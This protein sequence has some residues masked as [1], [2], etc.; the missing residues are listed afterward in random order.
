MI[1][2]F[3]LRFI[4]PP[5]GACCERCGYFLPVAMV[6]AGMWDV[7]CKECAKLEVAKLFERSEEKRAEV[8]QLRRGA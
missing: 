2:R 6:G 4:F 5:T 3:I 7:W 8:V 1:I